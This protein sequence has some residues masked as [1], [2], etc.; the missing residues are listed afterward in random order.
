QEQVI[1]THYDADDVKE[2]NGTKVKMNDGGFSNRLGVRIYGYSADKKGRQWQ[3]FIEANWL[4]N[5]YT[6][7]VKM[8]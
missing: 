8:D 3:P 5:G 4:Y 2:D 7:A 6:D 1:Y